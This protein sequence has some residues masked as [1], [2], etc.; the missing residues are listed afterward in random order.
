MK[1][2]IFSVILLFVCSLSAQAQSDAI[3]TTS[4][5]F[6]VVL[7]ASRIIYAPDSNGAFL[8]ITNPQDYP[9]LA[10]SQVMDLDKTKKGPFIVTPPLMRLDGKQ[11]SRL[12]IV[13]T[14]GEFANDRESLQ[15]LCVK[16][17]PPKSGD[18]WSK[19]DNSTRFVKERASLTVKLSISNCIKLFVR[20]LSLKGLPEDAGKNISWIRQG[21]MIK[22]Y[23][24]SP[25][26]VNISSLKVNGK[27]LSNVNYIAPFSSESYKLP[28]AS[29]PMEIH[30]ETVN[31]YGGDSEVIKDIVK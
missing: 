26:Y 4:K 20:P 16:G 12:R 13:R 14:G 8:T 11:S 2:N 7:G 25:F 6:S 30:W 19:S 24:N 3:E 23:N 28:K 1:K 21:D 10:Q 22:G 27:S 9:I 29:L 5:P 17:I 18:A 31:D 15:W